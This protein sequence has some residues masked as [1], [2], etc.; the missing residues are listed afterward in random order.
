G[1]SRVVSGEVLARCNPTQAADDPCR[2]K[3]RRLF[4]ICFDSRKLYVI[5]PDTGR[6]ESVFQTGRGPHAF[7]TDVSLSTSEQHAFGY[8]AHFTDSYI[9]VLDLDQGSP[10]YG[11]FLATVGAPTA[12][13]ASK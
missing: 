10:S 12:P 1:P 6:V 2:R 9:G 13:R 8:L 4:V 5:Q 7:A 11:S 3:E